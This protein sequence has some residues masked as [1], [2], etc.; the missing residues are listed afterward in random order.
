MKHQKKKH[1]ILLNL[2]EKEKIEIL[3]KAK[4]AGFRSVSEWIRQKLLDRLEKK[5]VDG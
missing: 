2:I 4:S 1:Q 3:R 5:A